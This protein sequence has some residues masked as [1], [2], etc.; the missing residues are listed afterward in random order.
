MGPGR[1]RFADAMAHWYSVPAFGDDA[2]KTRHVE[3]LEH[4]A[5]LCDLPA[6]DARDISDTF[7]CHQFGARFCAVFNWH[8]VSG[9]HRID[10]GGVQLFP[11]REPL[12]SQERAQ[13][14]VPGIT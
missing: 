1:E 4:G 10:F 8:L 12:A 7:W 13:A 3:G 5:Y 11:G 6:L 14:G 9:L 2:G